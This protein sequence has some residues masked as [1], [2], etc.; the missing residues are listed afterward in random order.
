M[1]SR[2][3]CNSPQHRRAPPNP[4]TRFQGKAKQHNPIPPARTQVRHDAHGCTYECCQRPCNQDVRN[5]FPCYRQ[6]ALRCSN[7]A[8]LEACSSETYSDQCVHEA[9]A[10]PAAHHPEV[11]DGAP[12]VPAPNGP[13]PIL[14]S[15]APVDLPGSGTLFCVVFFLAVMFVAAIVVQVYLMHVNSYHDPFLARFHDYDRADPPH[16]R[17]HT[18][19]E[20]SESTR[21]TPSTVP[22]KVNPR[23]GSRPYSSVSRRSHAYLNNSRSSHADDDRL[24]FGG[25]EPTA[26]PPPQLLNDYPL[27]P[28]RDYQGESKSICMFHSTGAGR[29]RNGIHYKPWNFPYHLCT[30]VVYCCAGIS[31]D[32]EVISRHVDIDVTQGF[33][34]AFAAMKLKNPHLRVYIGIGS[35]DKDRVAFAKIVASAGMRQQFAQNAVTWMRIAQYDGMVL[36]WRYPFMEQKPKLVDTMRYLRQAL[37]GMGLTVGIVVPLDEMLRERFNV[38]EL[39]KSLDDYTILIDPIDTQG[40]SYDSTFVPFRDGTVRMYAGVFM[41]TLRSSGAGEDKTSDGRF[42]LCYMFPVNAVS[43]TLERA[44]QTEISAPTVGPGEPGPSTETPG[45]LSYDEVCSQKWESTRSVN[46]GIVSTRG[47]QWVVYQNRS[48]LYE[49]LKALGYVTGPA[50]CFGIWDPF[51][52]DFAGSCGEGPYPLTRAIFAR[53]V[54]HKIPFQKNSNRWNLR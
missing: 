32:L 2:S 28:P 38:S 49:L 5:D 13:V 25:R 50:K 27:L 24:V 34:A 10:A 19:G 36:Y 40:P 8:P 52:D 42:Q 54:G 30:H 1:P 7:S 21:T 47:N 41:S 43:F 26:A 20:R 18:Y 16:H 6:P 12:P 39:S 11:L 33:I 48:S 29:T 17:Q 53:V 31:D 45:S 51:W 3:Q 14:V 46:Y 35:D 37:H 23:L 15:A 44:D 9:G 4:S 22:W